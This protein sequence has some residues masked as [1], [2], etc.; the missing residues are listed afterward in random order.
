M[1]QIKEKVHAYI[2][3]V[4]YSEAVAIQENTLIFQE[5]LL[6]S[7]GF[8]ML[9]SFLDETFGVKPSDDEL[10]EENFESIKAITNYVMQKQVAK[11]PLL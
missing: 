8:I 11:S 1:S 7:M 2:L 10:V 5:G 4:T 6:D 9:L 3:E